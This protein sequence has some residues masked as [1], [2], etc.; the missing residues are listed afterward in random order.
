MTENFVFYL[1]KDVVSDD[2]YW[3]YK[4]SKDDVFFCV[5]DCTGHGVPGAFMSMIGT[6]LLNENIIE[7]KL[8]NPVEILEN[9]RTKTIQSLN[10]VA[11]KTNNKD[12]MDMSL[13]MIQFQEKN[14]R[15]CWC[16]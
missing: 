13:C 16:E 15:I 4:N 7:N 14:F 2:Y 1:L 8:E 6:S 12:G 10:D 3:A 5:A 9:M 11:T